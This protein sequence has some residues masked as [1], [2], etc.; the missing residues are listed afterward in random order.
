MRHSVTDGSASDG[1]ASLLSLPLRCICARAVP[2]LSPPPFP[3]TVFEEEGEVNFA[4]SK[5]RE[6]AQGRL[7]ARL[8]GLIGQLIPHSCTACTCLRAAGAP[9]THHPSFR[10]FQSSLPHLTVAPSPL[11]SFAG[12]ARSIPSGL[13]RLSLLRKG[14][15]LC[16][17][18]SPCY[19]YTY[20]YAFFLSLCPMALKIPWM[21]AFRERRG[22]WGRTVSDG[23]RCPPSRALLPPPPPS[24]STR[25]SWAPACVCIGRC[26]VCFF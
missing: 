1:M 2:P 17:D 19:I 3:R 4:V 11:P 21:C 15:M 26:P 10:A 22:Q 25:P 13:I 16:L 7:C 24:L 9:P 18:V 14:W 5:H 6:P 23:E 8:R 12:C 20:M